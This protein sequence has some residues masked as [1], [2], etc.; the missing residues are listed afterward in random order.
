MTRDFFVN[1][2]VEKSWV[3]LIY[4]MDEIVSKKTTEYI[5]SL[6]KRDDDTLEALEDYASKNMVPIVTKEVSRY[7][8]TLI[9]I[10]KPKKVLELG[11]A[12]GYSAILMAKS[13]KELK[14]T[15]IERDPK[16]AQVAR[17]NFKRYGYEDRIELIEGDALEELKNIKD[18]FDMVFI[19]AGKSHYNEFYSDIVSKIYPGGVILCDNVLYKGMIADDDLVKRRKKTIV[20]RMRNF[21]D[22]ICEDEK[23]I[24]SV[25][26]I[27]DGMSL[28]YVKKE[29]D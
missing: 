20:K 27:G 3:S 14:V 2:G 7:I 17:E 5:T 1:H 28:S 24:T 19:D 29:D 8:E 15:T 13:N 22:I 9:H 6:V 11:C 21:L 23:L 25:I 18:E 10:I 4:F 26:P 16:M 12:I